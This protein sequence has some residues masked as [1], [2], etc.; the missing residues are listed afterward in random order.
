MFLNKLDY[1]RNK[2]KQYI[3]ATEI[4]IRTRVEKIVKITRLEIDSP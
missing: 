1:N 4:N 3:L 2:Y